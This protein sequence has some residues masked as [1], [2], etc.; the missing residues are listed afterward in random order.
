[1]LDMFKSNIFNLLDG[2]CFT[3][4]ILLIMLA[5]IGIRYTLF[6][7]TIISSGVLINVK[8]KKIIGIKLNTIKPVCFHGTHESW[9]AITKSNFALPSG[10]TVYYTLIVASILTYLYKIYYKNHRIF[11]IIATFILLIILSG[12]L[13]RIEVCGFH[14]KLD[15]VAGILYGVIYFTIVNFALQ[16][17][18][19]LIKKNLKIKA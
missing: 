18:Y 15:I 12:L 17:G 10:H 16:K 11:Y 2:K 14:S 1:M 6:S 4:I 19:Y 7:I 9:I 5:V 13:Y 8:I 3:L